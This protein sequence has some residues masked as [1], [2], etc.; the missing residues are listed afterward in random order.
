MLQTRDPRTAGKWRSLT[1]LLLCA[2]LAVSMFF[3]APAG[4][5]AA[6]DSQSTTE[7]LRVYLDTIVR[8]AL[9]GKAPADDVLRIFYTAH[10]ATET[11]VQVDVDQFTAYW[12][13]VA[14]G[15]DRLGYVRTVTYMISEPGESRIQN[16]ALVNV[17]VTKNYNPGSFLGFIAAVWDAGIA[18]GGGGRSGPYY[19][20]QSSRDSVTI[21]YHL[22]EEPDGWRL[23]LPDQTVAAMQQYPSRTV[24]KRYM[25]DDTVSENGVTVQMHEAIVSKDATVL[26]LSIQNA[27]DA[28]VQVWAAFSLATLTDE[29]GGVRNVRILRSVFPETIPAGMSGIATLVFDPIPDDSRQLLLSLRGARLGDRDVDLMLSLQLAP[30]K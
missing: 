6:A 27:G 16:Q 26:L 23:V 4:A 13:H 7:P 21:A 17:T 30:A 20:P 28:E 9:E 22:A 29:T 5:Q 1:S 8:P 24:V 2:I 11:R 15:G 19:N 12:K 3:G 14:A 10:L 18:F 25:R